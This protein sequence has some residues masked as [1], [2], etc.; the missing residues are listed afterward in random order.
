MP[1]SV[2]KSLKDLP[3]FRKWSEAVCAQESVTYFFDAP[4]VS[5]SMKERIEKLRAEKGSK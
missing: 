2:G 3:N 1:A 5:K 4:S